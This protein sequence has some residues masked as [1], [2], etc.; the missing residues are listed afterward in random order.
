M[1]AELTGPAKLQT[2]NCPGCEK[3]R[4]EKCL[5]GELSVFHFCSFI[6]VEDKINTILDL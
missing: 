1:N 3:Q 4:T 5:D 6:A 2:E